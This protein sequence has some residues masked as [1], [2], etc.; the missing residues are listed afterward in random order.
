[1]LTETASFVKVL[2]FGLVKLDSPTRPK[3]EAL[4]LTNENNVSGTPGYMAPEVVLGEPSDH[5]VDIYSLGCVAYWLV[6]GTLVS[7]LRDDNGPGRLPIPLQHGA[8]AGMGRAA[9]RVGRLAGAGS[10]AQR[11]PGWHVKLLRGR[12]RTV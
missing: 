9:A 7:R 5:R 2:D 1:M 3:D 10:A 12:R 11:R 4:R 8:S 6:T